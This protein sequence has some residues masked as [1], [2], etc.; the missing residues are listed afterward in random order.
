[1]GLEVPRDGVEDPQ[2][3]GLV[4]AAGHAPPED[5]PLLVHRRVGAELHALLEEAPQLSHAPL[6]EGIAVARAQAEARQVIEEPLVVGRAPPTLLRR[7]QHAEELAR[8]RAVPALPV[9]EDLLE[10]RAERLDLPA[11]EVGLALAV[12]GPQEIGRL[13]EARVELA[14]GAGLALSLR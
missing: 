13:A 7:E 8:Q 1:L 3:P 6:V 9:A 5:P 4:E 2:L 12:V 10:V 11:L 14:D